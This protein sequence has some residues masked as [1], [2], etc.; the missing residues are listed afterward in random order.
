MSKIVINNIEYKIHPV[1]DL[2]ADDENGNILHIAKQIPSIG[3][4][5]KLVYKMITVRKRAQKSQNNYFVHR[6]TWE[7]HNDLIPDGKV[8][9]QKQ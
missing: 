2:Y 3:H 9:D 8:I 5:S 4:S 6:F 7:C 1:Y